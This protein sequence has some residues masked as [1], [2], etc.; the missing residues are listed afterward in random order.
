[1]LLSVKNGRKSYLHGP[2]KAG[3]DGEEFTVTLKMPGQFPGLNTANVPNPPWSPSDQLYI[4]EKID[5]GSTVTEASEAN[6]FGQLGNGIDRSPITIDPNSALNKP[7]LHGKSLSAPAAA[8]WGSTIEVDSQLT[9]AGGADA[10]KRF[11]VQYYLSSDATLD[12]SDV[13]LYR[14]AGFDHL[15]SRTAN[16]S[17]A[18]IINATTLGNT[19]G[20][21]F[22]VHLKLPASLAASG[23]SGTSF[24]VIQKTDSGNVIVESNE[25]NN[26]G[27]LGLGTDEAAI[28]ITQPDLQGKSLSAPATANWGAN[29][30]IDVTSQITN[31]GT[32]PV[33]AFA[34][35]WYL[36][37][38]RNYSSNDVL[39]YD[40]GGNGS[41]IHPAF[42]TTDGTP[43]T[44]TLK[45]PTSKP[46]SFSGTSFYL[47]MRTDS[48]NVIKEVD[49]T[50]NSGSVGDGM[51]SVAIAI[52]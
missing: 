25:T 36:S 23:L 30:T 32:V 31:A 26:S 35:Q 9:N 27:S 42:G 38:D 43:F 10:A 21:P 11:N 5:S 4:V 24:Y 16:Y 52:T 28:T 18:P 46:G 12:G 34:V 37:M 47:V 1:V 19:D 3:Q 14:S 49:E 2:I 45:M 44:V 40:T 13:L 51:D 48:T 15:P 41:Y 50:N 6:N 20:N 8:V 17:H 7:D 39:L 29:K 22:D 33:S